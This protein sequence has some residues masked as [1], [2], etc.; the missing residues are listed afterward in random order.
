MMW[1]VVS[2]DRY[3]EMV[4][5]KDQR[6]AELEQERR[7]LWDKI[8]LLGI[9]AP[10]FVPIPQEKHAEKD[11]KNEVQEASHKPTR[12]AISMRPS[13]IM[14]RMERLAEAKWLQKMYPSRASGNPMLPQE[15]APKGLP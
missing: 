11:E 9:G 7:M 12:A 6:I 13:A 3:Q 5:L 1:P 4:A 10:A 15:P 2:R 14:R 8:C